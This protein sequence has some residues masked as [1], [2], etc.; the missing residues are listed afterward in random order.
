MECRAKTEFS[1][2]KKTSGCLKRQM[3]EWAHQSIILCTVIV[4]REI[5][6]VQISWLDWL[7]LEDFSGLKYTSH[8]FP[9][10]LWPYT[11]DDITLWLHSTAQSLVNWAWPANHVHWSPISSPSSGLMKERVLCFSFYFLGLFVCL[12]LEAKDREN[13]FLFFK[14]N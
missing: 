1:R 7:M 5:N 11:H 10:S 8:K 4:G 3:N 2:E 14:E 12:L 13:F 9:P 6:H